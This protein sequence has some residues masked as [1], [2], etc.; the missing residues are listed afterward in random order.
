[1]A[2]GW[3]RNGLG[4]INSHTHTRFRHCAT[5]QQQAH[6]DCGPP[7]D[8]LL[9]LGGWATGGRPRRAPMGTGHQRLMEL[10][11]FELLGVCLEGLGCVPV[12]LV[13]G[14]DQVG[15]E[16]DGAQRNRTLVTVLRN[17]M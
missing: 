14:V 15:R 1:M 13:C 17:V 8:M 11:F 7:Q 5:G 4:Q 16:I 3:L 6:F 12:E 9:S 10:E 2:L